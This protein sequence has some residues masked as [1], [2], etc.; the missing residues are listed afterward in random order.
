MQ[1]VKQEGKI[2]FRSR[3]QEINQYQYKRKNKIRTKHQELGAISR[4][5]TVP[6]RGMIVEENEKLTEKTDERKE[7]TTD[8][9]EREKM[10]SAIGSK[11]DYGWAGSGKL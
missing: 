6:T 8:L 10:S 4:Q 1:K 11:T 5:R 7:K 9:R 2:G 3:V